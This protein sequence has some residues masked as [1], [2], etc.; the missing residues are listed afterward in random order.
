MKTL[1]DLLNEGWTEIKEF[2]FGRTAVI[3][4]KGELNLI[5]DCEK[6]EIRIRPYVVYVKIAKHLNSK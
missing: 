2:G 6:D 4:G 1:N 3:Y 5:Y